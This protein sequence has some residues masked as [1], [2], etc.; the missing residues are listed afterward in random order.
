MH[1]LRQKL[2]YFICGFF[3][4]LY[5]AAVQLRLSLTSI[6]QKSDLIGAIAVSVPL[7][8][9]QADHNI[10]EILVPDN[11]AVAPFQALLWLIQ[12]V[13]REMLIDL[14]VKGKR[15]KIIVNLVQL[16]QGNGDFSLS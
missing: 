6:F 4:F 5:F 12:A 3:H 9:Q 7:L 15:I 11:S 8:L 13:A 10:E 1:C 16:S 14:S 2:F